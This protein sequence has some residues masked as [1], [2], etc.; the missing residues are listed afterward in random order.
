MKNLLLAATCLALAACNEAEAPAPETTET[1]AA[2]VTPNVAAAGVGEMAGTYEVT[3]AEGTVTME[4]LNADGTYVDMV[5]GT[6]TERGTWRADGSRTCFDP[7]GNAPETCYTGSTP[8][9][10]GTFRAI[11]PD[12]EETGIT[13]R[14]IEVDMGAESAPAE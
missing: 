1:P 4:T 3:D 8:D 2:T 14:K 13:V 6:E 10:E 9:A 7:A 12:G 11:G 5:D